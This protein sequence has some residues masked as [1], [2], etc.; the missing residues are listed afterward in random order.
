V[1]VIVI[2]RPGTPR[3]HIDLC[4]GPL[5]KAVAECEGT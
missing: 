1:K 4:G 5:R 3:Q 2:D